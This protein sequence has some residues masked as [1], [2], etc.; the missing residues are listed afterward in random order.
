MAD[1]RNPIVT[2][3]I[4]AVGSAKAVGDACGITGQAVSLWRHVPIEHV[5][6]VEKISGIPREELR[7]DVFGAPRPLDLVASRSVRIA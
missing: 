3:V 4:R 7:P 2:R 6:T 1:M 5:I